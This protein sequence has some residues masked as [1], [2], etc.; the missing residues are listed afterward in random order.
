MATQNNLHILDN[1]LG[2]VN[3]AAGGDGKTTD[4]IATE[5]RPLG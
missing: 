2:A 5:S 3:E 4:E 1:L